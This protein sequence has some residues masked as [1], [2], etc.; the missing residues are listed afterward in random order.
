VSVYTRPWYTG[1]TKRK[2]KGVTIVP[3]PSWKTKHFD[4]ITHAF[5]STVHAMKHGYDVYHFQGV[6]P[7]LL[8]WMPR[9]FRPTA[10][11]I[12]TFHCLDRR[13]MKWGFF[14]RL[15]LRF[16]EFAACKFSHDT[17]VVSKTLAH[18]AREVYGT[19]AKYIPNGITPPMG[20]LPVSRTLK[21]FSLTKGQYAVM[22]ARLT[23]QK[24]VH[25]LVEAWN[26]MK[27]S[28]DDLRV[29]SMK[30]VIVGDAKFNDEYI[31]ELKEQAK[32][33][34]DLVKDQAKAIADGDESTQDVLKDAMDRELLGYPAWA[35]PVVSH[36]LMYLRGKDPLPGGGEMG[37]LV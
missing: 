17:I 1:K 14:A 32:G 31:A 3:R 30:L 13:Q 33:S 15:I 22:V 36:G 4:A 9:V 28:T 5:V 21:K 24:G 25:V 27:E 35:A 7:S 26:K 34:M 18:Y 8:A 11:V 19:K 20:N 29:H 16:G 37:R 12:T 6:G 10:R 2:H 23:P